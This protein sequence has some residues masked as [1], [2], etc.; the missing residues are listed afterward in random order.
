MKEEMS[1]EEIKKLF[2]KTPEELKNEEADIIC[3]DRCIDEVTLYLGD[4][5]N[6]LIK[7]LDTI[8]F[9][10]PILLMRKNPDN[11]NDEAVEF[12]PRLLDFLKELRDEDCDLDYNPYFNYHFRR[13]DISSI[14]LDNEDSFYAD[15]ITEDEFIESERESWSEAKK[16]EGEKNPVLEA[17]ADFHNMKWHNGERFWEVN[18]DGKI[19]HETSEENK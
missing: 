16:H 5:E 3:Y 10:V 2:S 14:D 18:E 19:V 1:I 6:E 7:A 17:I 11:W 4:H 13:G 8:T 9:D 12:T 15:F